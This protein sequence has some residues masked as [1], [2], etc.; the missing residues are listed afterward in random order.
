MDRRVGREGV[1][2]A[3]RA[4]DTAMREVLRDQL[5]QTVELGI[6]PEVRIEPGELI[7]RSALRDPLLVRIAKIVAI[8]E[9]VGVNENCHEY[10]DPPAANLAPFPC[11]PEVC[12]PPVPAAAPWPRR[13]GG[14][15]LRG[16]GVAME[17]GVG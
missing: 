4:I 15:A 3:H 6:G 9:D 17:A 7:G 8:N 1:Y 16:S 2:S 12:P 10:R 14:A 13:T 11:P 5:R